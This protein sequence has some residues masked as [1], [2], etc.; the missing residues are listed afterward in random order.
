LIDALVAPVDL[1][2][3]WVRDD[4]ACQICMM[5]I[6]PSL[7]WPDQLSVTLDHEIPL[8]KGGTHEPDNVRLAHARCNSRKGDRLT[9]DLIA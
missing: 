2:E 7:V 6:D 1:A 9:A 3:I 8:S 5:A 4:G